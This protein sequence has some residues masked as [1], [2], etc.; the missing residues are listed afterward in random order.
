MVSTSKISAP[1]STP[2]LRGFGVGGN[3]LVEVDV[4]ETRIVDVRRQDWAVRLVGPSTPATKRGRSGFV[5]GILRRRARQSRRFLDIQ[6]Q[7][8]LS[9]P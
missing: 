3:Q 2:G 8:Q 5:V 6:F 4:A 1:P 9:M 7:R